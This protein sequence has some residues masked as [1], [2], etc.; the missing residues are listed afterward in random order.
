MLDD[1]LEDEPDPPLPEFDIQRRGRAW[2]R[3]EVLQRF[4]QIGELKFEISDGKLFLSEH[5]RLLLLG[6][7]LENVGLDAALRLGSP[8]GWKEAVAALETKPPK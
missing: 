6:M 4:R 5:S 3:D 2:V 1:H 8:E 7:L